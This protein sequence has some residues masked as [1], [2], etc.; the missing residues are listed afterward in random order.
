MPSQRSKGDER[1]ASMTTRVSR[2]R[3]ETARASRRERG[4]AL[5]GRVLLAAT[6]TGAMLFV[7]ALL[8][9]SAWARVAMT[10]S[11]VVSPRAVASELP[12]APKMVKQ[13]VAAT[14]E[15]GQSATFEATASGVPAPSV[16]WE[17]S[18]NAGST[19]TPIEGATATVLTI[20]SAKT[21]ENADKVRAVF[22][23]ASGK[24]TS[25]A[26]LL[27]VHKA[28]VVTKQPAEATVEE[29]QSAVFEATASAFPAATVQWELSSDGGA[30]WASVTGGT[31]TVLTVAATKTTYD[32][33]EYRAAFKNVAG[34]ATS[35]PATLTVRKA[36]AVTKQP[37]GT[38]V[39]EGQNATFEATASGFP[40]PTVQWQ[41]S[42]DG[43]A[44]W[45]PIE[46][47][48]ANVLTIV[49]PSR[50][51]SG[52][53]YRAVFSNA[54]GEVTTAAAVVSVQRAPSVTQQP[55]AQTVEEGQS[56]VFEAA[57]SGFPAPTVQ[58][59]VSLNGG[60]TWS[61]IAGA[62]SDQLTIVAAKTTES[63]HVL[64]AV[65]KNG[66]GTAT[67]STAALT[68]RRA[69]TITKQPVSVTVN[70]GF[71][72]VFEAAAAGFPAPSVQWQLSSD[73]GASWS[74]IEGATSSKLTI[75]AATTAESGDQYRAVF[76]NAAGEAVTGA[77]TL[78]VHAPPTITEQPASM[79]VEAGQTAVF[80]VSATGQPTPT[81]QW[82]VS[83][84]AGSTWAPI[85]GATDEQ[86]TIASAAVSEGGY[87]FRAVFTNVAGSTTSAV[88]TLTVATNHYSAVAWGD[89]LNRQLGDGLSN[90]LSALPVSVSNLKFVTAVAAGGRHS[91][92]LL[93]NSTVVAWGDNEFGQLGDATTTI[94]SVPVAVKGVTG[95]KTIA[96]GANHSLA[97]LANGTVMAW[98]ANEDGQLGN[99]TTT[100]SSLPVA[101]K[102]LTA[103]KAI[104]AGANHSLALLANGTVMAWGENEDGQLG[105]GTVKS[106]TVPVPVKGLTGV[107]AV[108]A[109][110]ES[111]F[112][113]LGKGTVEAWGSNEQGQLGSSTGEEVLSDLPLPV[114]GLSGV[115]SIVAGST[116]ALALLSGGTVMAWGEDTFGQLG[117]GAFAPSHETPVAVSGLSGVTA[118]SAGRQDSVALLN[119]GSVM[120]WGINQRG[121]LGDGAT[122]APSDVPVAVVGISKVASVSAG[123]S[124][125]LAFGEPKPTV[126][127]VSPRFGPSAGGTTVTLTGAGLTGATSVQFGTTAATAVDVVSDTTLTAVAPAGTGAVDITVTTPSGVSQTSAA[128]RFAYQHAPTVTKLSVK[129]GPL[130]GATS[131][132]I[133][134]S[135]FAGVTGV[136]FGGA[137]AVTFTVNSPTSITA[138]SPQGSAAGVLDV[139]VANSGGTSAT[140]SKDHFTY[141]PTVEGVSPN[142]GPTAAGASVTVSGTGFALGSTA[143]V[144]KF[145]TAKA[146]SVLCSSTT[147]CTMKAPAGV[148]GTVDVKATA[149][150]ATS[151]AS[152]PGDSY[153][154]G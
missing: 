73:G 25:T 151:P 3:A 18:I 122:G 39:E 65:F 89:N 32:G 126:T 66:A 34:K 102:G 140:S 101:V 116:H 106:S 153:T 4:P 1:M 77:A 37:L 7:A 93:A 46:G 52:S 149:N 81:V 139:T 58:W 150:K 87:E 71:G 120:S 117:N 33:R 22:T 131:V 86:L 148:A 142:S 74:A 53:E 15:E 54:A 61:A 85:T 119:Q 145:G 130:A 45:S 72:A 30:T 135:E 10:S 129:S 124:H 92:A 104:S 78:T 2:A 67:S 13:P 98:G 79:T 132:T 121:T 41:V 20:A 48:T 57:A 99:G 64:R 56:A 29:G 134:G 115:A 118:I 105:N 109:G 49:A 147:T 55:V 108:S 59:E 88:V 51:E 91:L 19:Y 8:A 24:A 127:A 152:A 112:A 136:S 111:S 47:A 82:E 44:S 35:E 75:A 113:L 133:T 43:A 12:K 6:L 14:V 62:G 21:S 128:D 23:N 114:T 137:A 68:V 95:V 154:F 97:L 5:A 84:N 27:T 42:T 96:A 76:A 107:A 83:K 103:V 38:T 11:A 26:V 143:T 31:S 94:C 50:A 146:T 40:A 36:P 138:V 90:G 70:E 69:P 125:M 123:G 9:S 80:Q 60:S 28:P 63:G 141:T 16:Q 17:V 100:E 144:F 110:G